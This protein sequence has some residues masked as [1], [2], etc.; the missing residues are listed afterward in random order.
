M[1]NTCKSPQFTYTKLSRCL[2]FFQNFLKSPYIKVV[3]GKTKVTRGY[4]LSP[5]GVHPRA[6]FVPTQVEHLYLFAS[7]MGRFTQLL[8]ATWYTNLGQSF[9]Y[10]LKKDL[11]YISSLYLFLECVSGPHTRGEGWYITS[12]IS[13]S[14]LFLHY[15]QQS[16]HKVS[17]SVQCYPIAPHHLPR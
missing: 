5:R 9:N 10:R 13:W 15:F 3:T 7:V 1:S 17:P 2:V 8:I 11:N 12:E 6:S 16:S 14:S 4:P